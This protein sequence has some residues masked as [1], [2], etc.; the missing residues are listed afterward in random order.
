MSALSPRSLGFTLVELVVVVAIIGL[1]ASIAIP[2]FLRYQLRARSSE[3]P[4]NLAA[5]ATAQESYYAEFG[6]Y[7]SV[8]SPVPAI[9]PG[10]N[11]IPWTAG[12][13][14]DTLGWG[15]EGGVQFQYRINADG[16]GGGTVRFTA[17][18]RGDVDGNGAPNFWG[19]VKPG[20]GTGLSGS[21]P[22]TT[23]VGTGV[24]AA[25]S[26]GNAFEVAG[27]CDSASGRT[28]F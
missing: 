26:S 27:P 24:V 21:F 15:A 19:Y 7:V 12:S 20:G 16:S 22:G 5:I 18:A 8:S 1:L 23:C 4:T 6:I 10:T 13:S 14:F 11:R 2:S 28:V 9:A 3:A 17:E 25:G